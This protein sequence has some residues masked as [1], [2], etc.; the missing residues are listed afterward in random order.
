MTRVIWFRCV[1]VVIRY[2]F[3]I[4]SGFRVV[5]VELLQLVKREQTGGK[6][7]LLTLKSNEK[8]PILSFFTGAGLLDLGFM[9]AGFNV[10]WH[11]EIE[12]WFVRGF[13]H[14]FVSAPTSLSGTRTISETSSIEDVLAKDVL[15]KAFGGDRP[16]LFGMIGGPPCPDFSIAGKQ[17]G[18]GGENG[19]LSEVYVNRILEILPAFFVFENVAGLLRTA[20]HKKFFSKLLNMVNQEYLTD[21]RVVNALNF[22]VPQD[23]ERVFLIGIRQDV[24]EELRGQTICKDAGSPLVEHWFDWNG[25]YSDAKRDFPWPTTSAFGSRSKKPNAVPLELT[26]EH[27]IRTDRHMLEKLANGKEGFKPYSDKFSTIREG[28]DSGKSFKRLHRWRYSPAAAYGNNEVHLHPT[29]KRRITVREA[30]RIQ[31][32]PDWYELPPEMP[33]SWKFKTIG[34]AVPVRLARDI[35]EKINTLVS[36]LVSEKEGTKCQM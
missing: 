7:K 18:G 27:A 21:H 5:C 23:R 22:G 32:V 3:P 16:D 26:V 29:R 19:R 12:P 31:T 20:K 24:V 1:E 35:A 30:M 25:K 2:F 15:S 4:L 28:D 17:K 13:E 33:L 34:N 10:C 8:I 11:N 9:E 6:G 14:A 36:P